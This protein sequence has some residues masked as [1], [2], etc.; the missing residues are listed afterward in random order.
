MKARIFNNEW[1]GNYPEQW[2]EDNSSK[3][4]GG[5]LVSGWTLVDLLPSSVELGYYK[6][7]WNG[8]G[9]Y[10]GA[11]VYEIT[12]I[13]LAEA[14]LTETEK[15]KQ[16]MIDGQNKYAEI[17]AKFRLLKLSGIITEESQ[18]DIENLFKPVRDE[19]LAGQWVDAKIQLELLEQIS[20]DMGKHDLYLEI[21]NIVNDYILQSYT[22]YEI[23]NI[24][25]NAR[26]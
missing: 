5:Q 22:T 10:E 23:E 6:L 21:W 13:R 18:R 11:S 8:V 20:I 17:S 7:K 16:R 26:K 24:E 1:A 2:L 3:I 14:I 9:Y 19:V 25:R 12:Q 15:Y 4:I